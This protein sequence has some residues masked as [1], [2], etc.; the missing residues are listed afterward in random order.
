MLAIKRKFESKNSQSSQEKQVKLEEK[1]DQQLIPYNDSGYSLEQDESGM[2]CI[3]K[4][5][6]VERVDVPQKT[7]LEKL[8]FNLSVK[9]ATVFDCTDPYLK[10]GLDFLF[11]VNNM[12][13]WHTKLYPDIDKSIVAMEPTG[14]KNTYTIGCRVKGKPSGF[15]FVDFGKMKRAKSTHGQFFSIQWNNIHYFNKMYSNIM[16]KYFRDEF[17][18]KMEPSVCLHFSDS[19]PAREILLRKFHN[20]TRAKNAE[21]YATGALTRPVQTE[22]TTMDQFHEMFELNKSEGPFQEVEMLICGVIEGVKYGKEIQMTD[23]D[24]RK[25]TDKPY[26]LAFKPIL[27]FNI[28]H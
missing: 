9:N 21:I 25:Y 16:Q 26:S 12:H 1:Q 4:P 15:G 5:L 3:F 7:W 17:A 19:P 11:S 13:E 6:Q 24:N 27:F 18:F 20:I 22:R 28:E 14:Q 23:M 10:S 8:V 2:L